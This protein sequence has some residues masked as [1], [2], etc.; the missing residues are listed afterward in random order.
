MK[1][2]VPAEDAGGG[3]DA[4]LAAMLEEEQEHGG[5][6][7]RDIHEVQRRIGGAPKK[8]DYDT[9]EKILAQRIVEKAKLKR[10]SLRRRSRSRRRCRD[11]SSE[12]EVNLLM[13]VTFRHRRSLTGVVGPTPKV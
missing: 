13:T 4:E 5:K 8:T 10:T 7:Q 12:S 1:E 6:V 2:P 9:R 3:L 11:S